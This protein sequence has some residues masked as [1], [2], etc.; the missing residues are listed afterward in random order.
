MEQQKAIELT[1]TAAR[2]MFDV[3]ETPREKFAATGN[4]ASGL[5]RLSELQELHLD[6]F[7]ADPIGMAIRA[8]LR[9]LFKSASELITCG[10][11][12]EAFRTI[13]GDDKASYQ[14]RVSILDGALDGITFVDQVTWA[15]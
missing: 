5:Y 3:L 4:N 2:R 13:C 10:Q 8:G 15:A 12:R 7:G 14:R 6:L 9:A 11:M 1:V